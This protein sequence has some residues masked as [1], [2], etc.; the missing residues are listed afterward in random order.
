MKPWR[1]SLLWVALTVS[2]AD[3]V[4][5]DKFRDKTDYDLNQ[6]MDGRYKLYGN[7]LTSEGENSS[8]QTFGIALLIAYELDL[9]DYLFNRSQSKQQVKFEQDLM[10]LA[11]L[12]PPI[13]LWGLESKVDVKRITNVTFWIRDDP[14][15]KDI[16]AKL[17]DIDNHDWETDRFDFEQS[18]E[19]IQFE[20]AGSKSPYFWELDGWSRDVSI[21]GSWI[22]A[23]R[24]YR[25]STPDDPLVGVIRGD[26]CV[27]CVV[28]NRA[29]AD[30]TEDL[31]HVLQSPNG[32][33]LGTTT[34]K[35]GEST[36][37]N[38]LTDEEDDECNHLMQKTHKQRIELF[39]RMHKSVQQDPNF[40]PTFNRI[41]RWSFKDISKSVNAVQNIVQVSTHL[42]RKLGVEKMV[43]A[44]FTLIHSIKEL[45]SEEILILRMLKSIIGNGFECLSKLSDKEVIGYIEDKVKKGLLKRRFLDE[46]K[47]SADSKTDGDWLD[48]GLK[49]AA[50]SATIIEH[51]SDSVTKRIEQLS[52]ESEF[53]GDCSKNMIDALAKM[54]AGSKD[55]TVVAMHGIASCFWKPM[56]A[57]HAWLVTQLPEIQGPTGANRKG[58]AMDVMVE[59]TEEL[60][61]SDYKQTKEEWNATVRCAS[62]L[63]KAWDKVKLVTA[64]DIQQS[65]WMESPPACEDAKD[66]YGEARLLLVKQFREKIVD[67]AAEMGGVKVKRTTLLSTIKTS[68]EIVTNSINTSTA[69]RNEESP[70]SKDFLTLLKLLADAWATGEH[71]VQKVELIGWNY[72]LSDERMKAEGPILEASVERLLKRFADNSVVKRFQSIWTAVKSVRTKWTAI[73]QSTCYDDLAISG[74]LN[75]DALVVEVFK[76]YIWEVYE[77]T[78]AETWTDNKAEQFGKALR[79]KVLTNLLHNGE[80][81]ATLCTVVETFLRCKDI[82]RKDDEVRTQLCKKAHKL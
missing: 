25:G 4:R 80:L 46:L 50:A 70:E 20:K 31:V 1:M 11:N 44:A 68:S 21:I 63:T 9:N 56:G 57:V 47:S 82:N 42:G 49:L 29:H 69:E 39:E 38:I 17:K 32:T 18:S 62:V 53:A 61:R 26:K 28:F 8:N 36:L 51:G 5:I 15:P 33:S 16:V 52:R 77:I 74:G 40:M 23:S 73:A 54:K 10:F 58:D 78:D 60:Y 48:R 22:T 66:I 13:E 34:I 35:N 19:R 72:L 65:E 7:L 55:M 30:G 76:E 37:L 6:H 79:K 27:V 14:F 59:V 81:K 71:V 3:A 43:I 2:H 41:M 12:T 67:L 45:K 75:G 24:R 64:T